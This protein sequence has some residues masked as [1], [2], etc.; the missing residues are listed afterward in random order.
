MG[1]AAGTAN[2]F[3]IF[4]RPTLLG[5]L[6]AEL[7]MRRQTTLARLETERSLVEYFE[8]LGWQGSAEHVLDDLIDR[9]VLMQAG[10]EVRSVTQP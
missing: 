2:L 8:R 4:D 10:D 3:S 5:E 6:A 1:T 7:K 9:R